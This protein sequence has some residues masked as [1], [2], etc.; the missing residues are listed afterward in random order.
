M[1][2]TINDI[3]MILVQVILDFNVKDIVLLRIADG[4]V[5]RSLLS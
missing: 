1:N 2:L 3:L 5:L 4:M